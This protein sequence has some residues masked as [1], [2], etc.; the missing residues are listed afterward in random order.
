MLLGLLDVLKNSAKVCSVLLTLLMFKHW[1]Y[2][3]V[4]VTGVA[5]VTDNLKGNCSVI[6][7]ESTTF[8]VRLS[9]PAH[10]RIRNSKEFF[11]FDRSNYIYEGQ[12]KSCRLKNSVSCHIREKTLLG[13]FSQG[14][15][16]SLTEAC[17]RFYLNTKYGSF[18]PIT[19]EKNLWN[20]T[21]DKDIHLY[22]REHQLSDTF[23]TPN[24][25]TK[26][27]I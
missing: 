8:D 14:F 2:N 12:V 24:M 4:Y 9:D 27:E 7:I 10:V 5:Y 21:N 1:A 23:L 19:V 3:V 26:T 15:S 6:P 18:S 25:Q 13:K 22:C 16:C 20:Y 17:E 11:Y